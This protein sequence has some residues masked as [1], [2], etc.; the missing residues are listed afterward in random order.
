MSHAVDLYNS[1]TTTI[2]EE[3][4]EQPSRDRL[5]LR[6][7]R[8]VLI[9]DYRIKSF[10]VVRYK[11]QAGAK[12]ST[13]VNGPGPWFTTRQGHHPPPLRPVCKSWHRP[14]VMLSKTES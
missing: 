3:E 4:R 13:S 1:Y 10:Y 5:N 14:G 9:D 11:H 6:L 2:E 12:L 7:I 8:E